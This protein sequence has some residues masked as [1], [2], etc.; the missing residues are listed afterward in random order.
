MLGTGAGAVVPHSD[1]RAMARALRNLITDDDL[2]ARMANVAGAIGS[3]LHWP[4]VADEYESIITG[5][6]SPP[7]PVAAL[8]AARNSRS[9]FDDL[10]R[11]G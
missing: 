8:P 6:L 10:A 2:A 7:R 3:T 9:S 5:L 4:V 11:V 1:P